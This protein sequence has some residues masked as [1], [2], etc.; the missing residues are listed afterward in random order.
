MQPQMKSVLQRAAEFYESKGD[1]FWKSLDYHQ[2]FGCVYMDFECFGM[3]RPCLK[4]DPYK[5]CF[6]QDADAWYVEFAFGN[7]C[8]KKLARIAKAANPSIEWLGFTRSNN[9]DSIKFYN[10]NNF[11]E[12]A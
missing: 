8:V 5:F 7:N 9:A 6:P 4:D 11:T 2:K 10:L 1:N 3:M 12:K